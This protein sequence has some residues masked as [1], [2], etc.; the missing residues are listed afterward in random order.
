MISMGP[1]TGR[2]Q[3]LDVVVPSMEMGSGRR[4]DEVGRWK[5]C[6]SLTELKAPVG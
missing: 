6:Y 2:M 4:H 5:V 1:E 3:G